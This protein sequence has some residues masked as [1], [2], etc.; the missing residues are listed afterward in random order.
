M[1]PEDA[2]ALGLR[3]GE[4]VLVESRYGSASVALKITD[5]T[6]SGLLF[7]T[8]HDPKT[9][10]NRITSPHRDRS[11]H[12]PEYKITAVAVRRACDRAAPASP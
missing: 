6:A 8:F 7:A 4:E 9:A 10:L 12:T 5:R 11:V 3:D 2:A 1:A